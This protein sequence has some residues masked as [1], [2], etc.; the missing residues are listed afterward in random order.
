MKPQNQ[1]VR[2]T[3][4]IKAVED[5]MEGHHDGERERTVFWNLIGVLSYQ[6]RSESAGVRNAKVRGALWLMGE[7]EDSLDRFE[8]RAAEKRIKLA[9]ERIFGKG[10]TQTNSSKK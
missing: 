1:N 2:L 10:D 5:R 3:D 8:L 9:A 6:A 4:R 7:I